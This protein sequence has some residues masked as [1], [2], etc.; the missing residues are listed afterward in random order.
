LNRANFKYPSKSFLKAIATFP[1]IKQ[2]TLLQ[3]LQHRLTQ[4][5]IIVTQLSIPGQDKWL[6]AQSQVQQI[7]IATSNVFICQYPVTTI[8]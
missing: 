5:D 3:I 6:I 2:E 8:W 1:A 4:L 7:P